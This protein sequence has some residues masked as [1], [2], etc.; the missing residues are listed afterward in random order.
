MDIRR[1]PQESSLRRTRDHCR[2]AL[3]LTAHAKVNKNWPISPCLVEHD[4]WTLQV[5]VFR[6]QKVSGEAESATVER[7]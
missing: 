4:V 1:H 3:H 2:V 7:N 5:C 6:F